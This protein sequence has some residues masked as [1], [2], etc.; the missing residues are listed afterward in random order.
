LQNEQQRSG[1]E[2]DDDF[3]AMTPKYMFVSEAKVRGSQ[4][5]RLDINLASA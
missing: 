5:T 4:S 2:T 1:G 3:D